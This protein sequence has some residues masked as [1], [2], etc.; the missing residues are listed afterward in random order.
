MAC[1]NV[2]GARFLGATVTNIN[3]NLGW[4]SN[5]TSMTV[6]LVEDECGGDNF[7][8]PMSLVT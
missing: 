3:T 2:A 6:S 1:L 4:G 7:N 5:G 8:P